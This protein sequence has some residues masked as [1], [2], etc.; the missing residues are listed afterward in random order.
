MRL[1]INWASLQHIFTETRL[2]DVDLSKPQPCK[3]FVYM[4]RGNLSH[5]RKSELHK[6]QYTV[7]LFDC[8]HYHLE[9]VIVLWQMQKFMCSCTVFA[10]FYFQFEGNFPVQVCWSLYL[11]GRFIG[12]SFALRVW[13]VCIWRGL[14]MEGLIFGILR[15]I[16]SSRLPTEHYEQLFI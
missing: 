7:T 13:G 15:Y 2:E 6:Q 11:E 16:V 9:H 12:G 4:D 14:Y 5:W 8:N 3:Y 10:L 1:K